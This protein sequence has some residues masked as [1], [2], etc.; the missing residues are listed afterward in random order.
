MQGSFINKIESKSSNYKENIK[1]RVIVSKVIEFK[2]Y[3]KN[4]SLTE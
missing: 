3:Y 4:I 1:G 2:N